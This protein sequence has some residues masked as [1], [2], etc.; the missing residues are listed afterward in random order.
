M[1]S[2]AYPVG[3]LLSLYLWNKFWYILYTGAKG[4]NGL[5]GLKGKLEV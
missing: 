1:E 3:I 2:I 5:P 4:D